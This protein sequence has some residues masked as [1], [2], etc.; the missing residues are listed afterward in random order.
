MPK[1]AIKMGAVDKVAPLEQ[2]ADLVIKLGK[3]R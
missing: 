2:I 1:E 3:A